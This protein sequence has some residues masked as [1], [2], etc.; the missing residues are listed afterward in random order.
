MFTKR[1][2]SILDVSTLQNK[3]IL[4]QK[5]TPA[6]AAIETEYALFRTDDETFARIAECLGGF[7]GEDVEI[8]GVNIR[9]TGKQYEVDDI[10]AILLAGKEFYEE[11][12]TLAAKLKEN[13]KLSDS[14]A[15]LLA[16]CA[17]DGYGEFVI[18][19][20]NMYATNGQVTGP[21]LGGLTIEAI[22]KEFAIDTFSAI[23]LISILGDHRDYLQLH[24]RWSYPKDTVIASGFNGSA[25]LQ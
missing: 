8:N 10:A 6:L 7:L 9:E 20:L 4:E 18:S 14:Y 23:C 16:S 15:L 17:I 21:V 22:L 5:I 12:K 25:V 24:P 2:L 3:L 1:D 19:S 13:S 11:T